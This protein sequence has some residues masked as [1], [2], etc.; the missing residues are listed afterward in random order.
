MKA[1]C[2]DQASD[3]C[4]EC[5]F[6]DGALCAYPAERGGSQRNSA[7]SDWNLG[8]TGN[9]SWANETGRELCRSQSCDKNSA[10]AGAD[11]EGFCQ[12]DSFTAHRPQRS[13]WGYCRLCETADFK[14]AFTVLGG[15][16]GDGYCNDYAY[17]P[18]GSFPWHLAVTN[19]LYD[20]DRVKECMNRCLDAHNTDNATFAD[21]AFYI[22]NSDLRCACATGNCTNRTLGAYTSYAITGCSWAKHTTA[23][24]ILGCGDGTTCNATKDGWGCCG[25]HGKRAMCPP[26]LP[27]MCAND[28]DCGGATD[29]CC[30]V[31]CFGH[32]P[33]GGNRV[34]L[35]GQC[36]SNM[37]KNLA[38]TGENVETLTRVTVQQ[39]KDACCARIW[40]KSFDYHKNDDK[41]DLSN[42]DGFFKCDLDRLGEKVDSTCNDIKWT[43]DVKYD[44]YQM[45]AQVFPVEGCSPRSESNGCVDD[46]GTCRDYYYED[47]EL[48]ACHAT[49]DGK[50]GT[51]CLTCLEPAKVQ[52]SLGYYTCADNVD[53]CRELKFRDTCRCTCIDW[54]LSG[55]MAN[56][57][58]VYFL[59]T[60]FVLISQLF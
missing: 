49:L 30:E 9:T 45:G 28:N 10:P 35:L 12:R 27:N 2:Y 8:D 19:P 56:G 4:N 13:D 24:F 47:N 48:C 26:N 7:P 17:L 20:S 54:D 58:A 60:L 51:N 44:H 34:C 57:Q 23:D 16:D 1:C 11:W 5:G 59:A 29:H 39:C 21:K 40:C 14:S 42:K 31:D 55:A 25:A 36:S 52:L 53:K 50:D 18:E 38:I 46:G 32:G 3:D 41:C 22:R 43:K 33:S 37:T 6:Y 15:E